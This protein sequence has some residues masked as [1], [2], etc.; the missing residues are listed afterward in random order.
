MLPSQTLNASWV[1]QDSEGHS[2]FFCPNRNLLNSLKERGISLRPRT[3]EVTDPSL[4]RAKWK[5]L[6]LEGTSRMAR[7][8]EDK[9]VQLRRNKVS[10][11]ALTFEV[12]FFATA[13]QGACIY[14]QTE[15][16]NCGKRYFPK[17]V[18]K[19][20]KKLGNFEC[21]NISPDPFSRAT[22]PPQSK[23]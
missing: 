6:G 8:H 10:F 9:R 23:A 21:P 7:S 4:D 20:R 12:S 17:E 11:P 13:N 1:R 3:R 16:S 14:Y 5:E 19:E 22:L 2:G 18:I 15:F